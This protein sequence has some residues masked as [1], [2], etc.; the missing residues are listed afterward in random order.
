MM[1]YGSKKR[2]FLSPFFIYRLIFENVPAYAR[3]FRMMI[4]PSGVRMDSGWNWT[5]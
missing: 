4:S 1:P 5:P 3:K 2:G